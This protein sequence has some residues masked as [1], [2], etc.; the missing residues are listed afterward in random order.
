MREPGRC[1]FPPNEMSTDIPPHAKIQLGF[2]S[3]KQTIM[4]LQKVTQYHITD[5][6]RLC[7]GNERSLSTLTCYFES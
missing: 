7:Q 1:L 3:A 2:F 6:E 4:A 5:R